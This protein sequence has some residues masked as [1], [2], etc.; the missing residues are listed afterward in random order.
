MKIVTATIAVIVSIL[1]ITTVMIPTLADN[2]SHD[3]T[4]SNVPAGGVHYTYYDTTAKIPNLTISYDGEN[5]TVNGQS[6]KWDVYTPAIVT[7]NLTI[8]AQ[9]GSTGPNC[10]HTNIATAP[11]GATSYPSQIT[12]LTAIS[13]TVTS[14]KISGTVSTSAGAYTIAETTLSWAYVQNSNGHYTA[15][16]Q[17]NGSV[18]VSSINDLTWQYRSGSANTYTVHNGKVLDR[19]GAETDTLANGDFTAVE[20][21]Y[22]EGDTTI[23]KVTWPATEH[24]GS[25]VA[26]AIAPA[27]YTIEDHED[28][29]EEKIL[30]MLP[31]ILMVSL[32]LG[33]VGLAIRRT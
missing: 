22:S 24:K 23:L 18:Y 9:S 30:N 1:A 20:T 28:T 12:K 15:V 21:V 16:N 3:T 6:V 19:T 2:V 10:T 25:T 8:A 17:T 27:S 11:A 5:M 14:G 4:Y 7:S 29:T 13:L 31:L 33:L 26:W 32:V